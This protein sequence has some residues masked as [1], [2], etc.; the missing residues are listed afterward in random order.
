MHQK[1]LAIIILDIPFLV[2]KLLIVAAALS[3]LSYLATDWFN[4]D[5]EGIDV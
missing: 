4:T 5:T 2:G 3:A 1:T